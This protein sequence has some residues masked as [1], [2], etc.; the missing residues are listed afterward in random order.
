MEWIIKS[1]HFEGEREKGKGMYNQED[2][3]AQFFAEQDG[4]FEK[5]EPE[6]ES[7]DGLPSIM[8][9]LDEQP[10]AQETSRPSAFPTGGFAPA[11]FAPETQEVEE[12]AFEQRD[13]RDTS[14]AR[15]DR[16]KALEAEL[17]HNERVSTCSMLSKKYMQ[18][19]LILIGGVALNIISTILTR[20]AAND[21]EL[22]VDMRVYMIIIAVVSAG[23]SVLY[24]LILLGLG[25]SHMDFKKAG[26]Y[27]MIYGA[28]TAVANSTTGMAN[29]AFAILAAVFS[30]LY[31][32]K[33]AV[34]MSNSFDNVASYMAISW[35]SFKRVFMYVY[36]AIVVCTLACFFPVLGLVAA[37]VLI[38][39]A[40]AAIGVS[41]WQILLVL[42]S[43]QVM[44]QYANV[45]HV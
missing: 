43:S 39:L 21:Y 30:V 1:P 27:Y 28:F 17:E 25:N 20:L 4:A 2:E 14:A 35:E 42:R 38:G 11:Q 3:I 10:K 22:Y 33:F 13:F 19:F 18:M 9:A 34:A 32:L 7:F 12:E 45:I 36:G 29:M 41:I 31:V 24:G 40:I 23:L 16:L 44:K 8:R 6:K 37:F 15:Y 5:K 26:L